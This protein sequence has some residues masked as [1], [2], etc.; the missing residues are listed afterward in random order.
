MKDL[1]TRTDELL[2]LAIYRLK[3]E[4]YTVPILEHLEKVS[5]KKNWTLAA[6]Y[7]PL[8]KLEKNGIVESYLGEP[9]SQRGGRSKRYYRITSKGLKALQE[10]KELERTMW[11]GIP[12]M[13]YGDR[14]NK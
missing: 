12:D 7:I 13:I 8:L 1:L 10:V 4:A 5:A 11:E 9:T 3:E 6:I 2:L 14:R